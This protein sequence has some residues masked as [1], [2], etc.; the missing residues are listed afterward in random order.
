MLKQRSVGIIIRVWMSVVAMASLI[1]AT[2]PNTTVNTA[3]CPIGSFV[4]CAGQQ[5][6]PDNSIV[7]NSVQN[8]PFFCQNT[9]GLCKE[10]RD[11]K[12]G[13][14]ENPVAARCFKLAVRCVSSG[15]TCGAGNKWKWVYYL[16]IKEDI[17]C[18]D[19]ECQ[20]AG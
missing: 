18:D 5:P 15:G 11:Q 19:P 2:C 4:V 10:C 3:A 9:G 17:G 7:P 20:G 12:V 16:P 8:G 6:C 13:P 14:G 1:G